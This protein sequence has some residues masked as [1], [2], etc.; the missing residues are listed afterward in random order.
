[1]GGARALLVAENGIIVSGSA[2][3]SEPECRDI[4]VGLDLWI[5][6]TSA[7][8]YDDCLGRWHPEFETCSGLPVLHNKQ[9]QAHA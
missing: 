1:M 3:A 8:L 7:T 6:M 9:C 5:P 4:D 2:G